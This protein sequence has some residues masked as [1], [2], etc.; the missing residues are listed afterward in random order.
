MRRTAHRPVLVTLIALGVG[1]AIRVAG[2]SDRPRNER[3]DRVLAV[4]GLSRGDREREPGWDGV[5]KLTNPRAKVYDFN[6]DWAPDGSKLA[7]QRDDETGCR[8]ACVQGI[9]TVNADGTQ[10][11]R[12]TPENSEI[13]S[14]DPAYSPDGTRIAFDGCIGPIVNDACTNEGIFVMTADGRNTEQVTFESPA[15]RFQDNEVQWSPDG[16]HFVFQRLRFSDGL[17]AVYTV[18][19]DGTDFHRLSPWQLDG[20]HADWSPDG[21]LIVFESYGD[22]APTGVSTNVFTVHPDGSHLTDVTRDEGGAVNATNP[23]WSPDGTKIVF[24]Q[25]PGSG[26][27]G[28]ADIFTMNADGS[29]IRQVTA[30]TFWDFRPD[31]GTAPPS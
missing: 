31:W 24:V 7:F 6:P 16:T 8:E 15:S 21:R 1:S 11:T 23:A 20:E 19:V 2:G 30:S 27:F 5:V 26:A 14:A 13:Y 22:G 29:D 18:K 9:Y 4:R 17:I 10:L 3:P 28:N 12:L 25:L